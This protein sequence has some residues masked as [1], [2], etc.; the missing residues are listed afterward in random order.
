MNL[1]DGK[2]T[3]NVLLGED[4][5]CFSNLILPISLSMVF[6]ADGNPPA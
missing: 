5:R 2:K 4:V 6:I 1:F 3:L